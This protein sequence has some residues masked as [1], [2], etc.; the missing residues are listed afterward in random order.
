[1]VW[2]SLLMFLEVLVE[3]FIFAFFLDIYSVVFKNKK[4]NSHTN[5]LNCDLEKL[6]ST[7]LEAMFY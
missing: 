7:L 1:M 6:I 5:S 4:K 3:I 2:L